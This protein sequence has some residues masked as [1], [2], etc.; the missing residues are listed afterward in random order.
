MKF[1]FNYKQGLNSLLLLLGFI[2]GIRYLNLSF[3]IEMFYNIKLLKLSN[4]I[5]LIILIFIL[6]V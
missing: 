4:I 3:I 6:K 5:N 1:F 2:I